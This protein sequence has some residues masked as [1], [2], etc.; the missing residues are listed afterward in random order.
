MDV[1]VFRF[2]R[3]FPLE[4]GFDVRRSC[5]FL[6]SVFFLLTAIAACGKK[7]MPSPPGSEPVPVVS[8]LSYKVDGAEVL[9]EWTVPNDISEGE[10][11]V[12]RTETKI[13]DETCDGCPQM[14]QQVVVLPIQPQP[15]ALKQTCRDSLS[16]GFRYTY[17]VV[18]KTDDGRTGG[19]SNLVTFD[20]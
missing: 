6:F 18:L 15:G 3:C 17:R 1:G 12:S 16:P 19:A 10:V 11:I 20:Y 9:L 5:L 8:D 14:F 7:A 2:P 13:S 4:A